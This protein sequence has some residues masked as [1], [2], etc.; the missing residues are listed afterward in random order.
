MIEDDEMKMKAQDLINQV[1]QENKI[2]EEKIASVNTSNNI[3]K[4]QT[5][6]NLN[7][8]EN[9]DKLKRKNTVINK[10]KLSV[11]SN[12]SSDSDS[13]DSSPHQSSSDDKEKII[14]KDNKKDPKKTSMISTDSSLENLML[15]RDLNIKFFTLV[16]CLFCLGTTSLSIVGSLIFDRLLTFSYEN[17]DKA[18]DVIKEITMNHTMIYVLLGAIACFNLGILIM[19]ALNN[20]HMLTKLILTELNWFFVLTQM[21]FGSLFLITLIWDTDLWTINVCLSISMLTILILAFYFTEIKQKKNMS[22]GTFVFI[23]IYIS[24]LFSFISYVA[25]YN[26]SCILL[27]NMEVQKSSIKDAV[28]LI[29][30]IGINAGQTILSFVLLTYYKDVFFSF[31][32]GYIEGAVFIHENFNLEKENIGLFVMVLLI[33]LGIIL[34]IYRYRKKTFGYEDVQLEISKDFN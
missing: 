28:S 31:T 34:T 13:Q 17:K 4:A 8:E 29:I 10:R 16:S 23:Y 9:P 2:K 18:D 26:I 11:E 5:S 14:Q 7:K 21:A 22:K 25:L 1:I 32:S 3:S 12:S 24:V 19:M 6:E 33:V 27:E 20:D 30:K 15:S